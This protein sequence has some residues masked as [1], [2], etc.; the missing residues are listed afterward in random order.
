MGCGSGVFLRAFYAARGDDSPW[1]VGFD[2]SA[3]GLRQVT[4]LSCRGSITQTPFAD[5]TFDLVTCLEVLEH[6]TDE[7]LIYAKKELQR[8]SRKYILIT[9]PNEEDLVLN[10][11]ICPKCSCCFSPW[12]H[13]RS[14]SQQD[15]IHFFE[16]YTLVNCTR[17]GPVSED[18]SYHPIVRGAHLLW[19]RPRPPAYSVC[20]QCNFHSSPVQEA[21]NPSKSRNHPL[22]HPFVKITKNLLGRRRLKK[23]WLLS[24]YQK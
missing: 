5:G 21:C 14:F 19:R 3:E 22:L 6:L 15:M 2:Q 13:L 10:L 11:V 7:E 20:P 4:G 23:K 1:G 16:H 12:G 17:V 9:T 8:V 24:V 18:C